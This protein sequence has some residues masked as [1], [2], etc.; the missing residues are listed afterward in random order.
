MKTGIA[1]TITGVIPEEDPP[2]ETT[3]EEAITNLQRT[4]E[5]T[6]ELKTKVM[7]ILT[8]TTM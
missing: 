6:P 1:R 2:E 5:E 7:A 3:V 4:P 8:P